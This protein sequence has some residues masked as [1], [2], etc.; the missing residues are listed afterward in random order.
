MGIS[1]GINHEPSSFGN[2]TSRVPSRYPPIQNILHPKNAG[3]GVRGAYPKRADV[4]VST[5]DF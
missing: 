1:R 4:G 3:F 5:G 2:S